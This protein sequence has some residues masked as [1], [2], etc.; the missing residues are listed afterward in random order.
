MYGVCPHTLHCQGFLLCDLYRNGVG[1][2]GEVQMKDECV[3]PHT[4][5]NARQTHHTA[6]RVRLRV[7]RSHVCAS[8]HTSVRGC[9]YDVLFV[10]VFVGCGLCLDFS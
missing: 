5:D 10:S 7:L 8:L 1:T 9:P 6:C 2:E 3:S 4:P